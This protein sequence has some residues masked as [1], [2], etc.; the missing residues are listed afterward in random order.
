MKTKVVSARVSQK[1][2]EKIEAKAK[3]TV[4]KYIKDLIK[5]DLK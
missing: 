2:Y 1:D 5:K 4:T 3:S